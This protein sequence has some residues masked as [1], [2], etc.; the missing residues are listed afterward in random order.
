MNLVYRDRVCVFSWLP[1][2]FSFWTKMSS[3]SLLRCPSGMSQVDTFTINSTAWSA[4]ED[5]QQPNGALALVKASTVEWFNK[6]YEMYGSAPSGNDDDYYLNF[7]KAQAVSARAD[8][9]GQG[10]LDAEVTWERVAGA[11]PPIRHAG[12][13]TFVGSRGSVADATFNDAGED[14]SGYGFPPALSFVFNLTNAAGTALRW[15]SASILSPLLR[16]PLLCSAFT[17]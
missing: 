10:L 16:S 11:V 6:G 8:V 13:R 14:A 2:T 1:W 4:C 7:T 3:S 17:H 15:A 5:L 9:L 12:V